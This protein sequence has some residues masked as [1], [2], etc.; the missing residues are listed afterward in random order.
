VS[1]YAP[2]KGDG[3]KNP[4]TLLAADGDHPNST[5]H[6][7]IASTLLAGTPRPIP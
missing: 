4:T 7:L 3:T 2:F 6:H 5:G 1:L